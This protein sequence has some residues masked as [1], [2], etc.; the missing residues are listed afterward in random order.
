MVIILNNNFYLKMLY[1]ISEVIFFTIVVNISILGSVTFLE[2][3]AERDLGYRHKYQ[4]LTN[5]IIASLA[6]LACCLTMIQISNFIFK[7]IIL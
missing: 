6:T 1:T 5:A 4:Q 2:M 7:E 3:I